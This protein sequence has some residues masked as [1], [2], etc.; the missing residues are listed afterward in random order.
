M[1]INTSSIN[2]YNP[3]GTIIAV[4]GSVPE[5]Y[6]P[7]DGSYVLISDYQNLYNTLTNDGS[8][9]NP[10]GADIAG[11]FAL[12]DLRGRVP[13]G[14]TQSQ[15]GVVDGENVSDVNTYASVIAV[16]ATGNVQSNYKANVSA[17]VDK[18]NFSCTLSDTDAHT[19]TSANMPAH[20]HNFYKMVDSGDTCRG[21][22]G[23]SGLNRAYNARTTTALNYAQTNN[24][25]DRNQTGSGSQVQISTDTPRYTG[26]NSG[27]TFT[28]NTTNH[29][30]HKL[31]NTTNAVNTARWANN[32]RNTALWAEMTPH[33]SRAHT[34]AVSTSLQDVAYNNGNLTSDISGDVQANIDSVPEL[35]AN[36]AKITYGSLLGKQVLVL[37]AI[38]Y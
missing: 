30:I 4:S 22:R 8:Q 28:R 9:N 1:T 33:L 12:P 31:Q 21:N 23:I 13:S 26:Q 6:L 3:T 34:H 27:E 14:G 5:G 32:N 7:C 18:G 20:T 25:R 35:T 15:V 2:V 37:Y 10:Y 29:Q 36:S 19:L 24:L 38:K 16:A 11:Q 17:S